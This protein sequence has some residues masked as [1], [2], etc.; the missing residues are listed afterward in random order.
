MLHKAVADSHALSIQ[1]SSLGGRFQL[2][3]LCQKFIQAGV[4]DTASEVLLRERLY[5]SAATWFYYEAMWYHYDS[6][7]DKD[8]PDN[9]IIYFFFFLFF[10]YFF[11]LFVF[12]FFNFF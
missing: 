5:A 4:C 10:I 6:A 1:P 9:G 7:K 3:L 11:Y 12:I 2:L 8:N